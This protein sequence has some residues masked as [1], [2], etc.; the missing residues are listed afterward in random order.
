MVPSLDT[1]IPA[2]EVAPA[3]DAPAGEHLGYYVGVELGQSQDFTAIAIAE[4]SRPWGST[5]RRYAVGHLERPALGTSYPAI[6]A[7]VVEL[8]AD[9]R[10]HRKGRPTLVVD[11][12][13]VGRPVVDM[14]RAA[15]PDADLLAVTIT[16]GTAV[17]QPAAGEYHVPKR[18]LASILAVLLQARRLS[19]AK[20]LPEAATLVKE[21]LGFRVK[22]SVTT[23]HDSYEAW[24]EGV[25]DDLVLATALATWAAERPTWDWSFSW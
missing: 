1:S 2:V 18:D 6:V 23:G 22:V 19:V 13:G 5:E 24:R 9:R 16:G 4:A 21:L 15:S 17:T 3:P 7:R 20:Q 14:F 10:L 8:C 11:Q 12:T 25:H